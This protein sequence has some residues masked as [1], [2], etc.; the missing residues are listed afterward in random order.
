MNVCS[1][2][3]ETVW[4]ACFLLGESIGDTSPRFAIDITL[5]KRIC[6]RLFV[7]SMISAHIHGEFFESLSIFFLKI[8]LQ[9]NNCLIKYD[10][11]PSLNPNC[12]PPCI[13]GPSLES[14]NAMQPSNFSFISN[15]WTISHAIF[16]IC[17]FIPLSISSNP[18]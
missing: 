16:Y 7:H 3:H 18:S 2:V 1:C 15:Y 6:H 13:S 12:G 10:T 4:H 11:F 9:T 17:G 14:M 8:N 5:Q